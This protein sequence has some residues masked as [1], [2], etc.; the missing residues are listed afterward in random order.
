MASARLTIQTAIKDRLE[1]ST[2]VEN[3]YE[4]YRRGEDVESFISLY[5]TS[6]QT[7][8]QTWLI[9]RIATPLRSENTHP[10]RIPIGDINYWHRFS[11]ECFYAYKENT[12]EAVFQALLDTVLDRFVNQRTLGGWSSPAPLS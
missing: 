12:S 11:V 3:V 2:G 8:V 1:G 7:A 4:D 9:H 5:N 6:D 10:G